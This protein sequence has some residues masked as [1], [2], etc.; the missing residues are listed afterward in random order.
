MTNKLPRSRA[1]KHVKADQSVELELKD[2]VKNILEESRMVLPGIQALFGFQLVAIFNQRFA[3]L[4][5]ENKQ[6]HI[7]AL[8]LT[9]IAIAFLMAPA[10]YHRQVE[11]NSVSQRFVDYTSRLLCLGMIPLLLS[12]SV[13]AYVVTNVA[14]DS[15]NLAL[16]IGGFSFSVL[17]ILWYVIPYY[18]R[19]SRSFS[20]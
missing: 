6:L 9:I 19:R 11:R 20:A 15:G 14:L 13:D 7:L 17:F 4:S 3:D 8:T 2:V 12:L 5:V 18:A 16:L 10:A 1:E